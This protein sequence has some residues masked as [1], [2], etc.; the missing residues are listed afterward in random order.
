M[1]DHVNDIHWVL[2]KLLQAGMRVS[3]EKSKCFKKS[4]EYFG[5]IVSEGG[6]RTSLEKVKAINEFSLPKTLFNLRSFLGLASYYRCFIKGFA[7][8]AGPLTGMLKGENGKVSNYQSRKIDIE[9]TKPTEGAFHK[10]REILA[11]EDVL[12]SYPDFT[13]SFDSGL[14]VLVWGRYNPK[15]DAPL[16]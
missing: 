14:Q 6:L 5:F 15:G 10:L 9:M 2:E 12:L 4:V 3:Q 8:I 11:S 7:S 1:G 13:K 16:P